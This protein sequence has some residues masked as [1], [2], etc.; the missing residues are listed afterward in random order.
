MDSW[1]KAEPWGVTLWVFAKP[2]ASRSKVVGIRNDSLAIAVAAP[3]VDGEANQELA[4][5]LAGALAVPRAA[6]SVVAGHSGRHKRLRIEG[7]TE[8][9]VRAALTPRSRPPN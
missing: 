5:F 6:V 7:V 2:R 1:L 3:P 9:A 4:S 8:E